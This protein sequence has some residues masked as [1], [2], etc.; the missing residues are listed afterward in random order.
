[1]GKSEG[2]GETEDEREQAWV[3]EGEEVEMGWRT[4]GNQVPLMG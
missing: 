1:M 3:E 4:K 2:L